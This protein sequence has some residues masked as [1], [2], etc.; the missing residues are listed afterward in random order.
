VLCHLEER[1]HGEADRPAPIPEVAEPRGGAPIS[2]LNAAL[3][4]VRFYETKTHAA[5]P[6]CRG[7]QRAG[8]S[9]TLKG[10]FDGYEA[11]IAE[12]E[13]LVAERDQQLIEA[14]A[15]LERYEFKCPKCGYE[16][17]I[18]LEE[19]EEYESENEPPEHTCG[20]HPRFCQA[21]ANENNRVSAHSPSPAGGLERALELPRIFGDFTTLN[22]DDSEAIGGAIHL[23]SALRQTLTER[24]ATISALEGELDEC[25]SEA[26]AE[27]DALRSELSAAQE[28]LAAYKHPIR[29]I[30]ARLES[31]NA[32]AANQ[33]C[34]HC[35]KLLAG[36]LIALTLLPKEK[37]PES[38]VGDYDPSGDASAV[39]LHPEPSPAQGEQQKDVAG[40]NP[41]DVST[42]CGSTPPVTRAGAGAQLL[43]GR[44][45][46]PP[47]SGEQA[48][49]PSR[50]ERFQ[51][52]PG[53]GEMAPL[54]HE[55]SHVRN[56]DSRCVVPLVVDEHGKRI[57]EAAAPSPEKPKCSM[58]DGSG[59]IHPKPC[60]W[61]RGRAGGCPEKSTCPECLARDMAERKPEA[62]APEQPD[63]LPF[64]EEDALLAGMRPASPAEPEKGTTLDYD[65]RPALEGRVKP[66]GNGHTLAEPEAAAIE[67][68][69]L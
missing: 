36:A 51:K 66:H 46:R 67:R 32:C 31:M 13:A 59:E 21:C 27:L 7:P 1:A 58:C 23:L 44:E 12:L 14:R 41:A 17:V 19:D 20:I 4:L 6:E 49:A 11:R 16:C 35:R 52:C 3:E 56:C 33:D 38:I 63:L 25:E 29:D 37:A 69:K 68:G 65:G 39:D 48:A 22:V 45:E 24:E 54:G 62:A 5:C 30:T 9:W 42:G 53:C 2:D 26:G 15:E 47:N 18:M 64:D 8:C 40:S 34:G 43:G 10:A 61:C 57:V 60:P 55:I 28:R 50:P